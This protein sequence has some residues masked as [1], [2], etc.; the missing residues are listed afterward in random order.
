MPHSEERQSS[1]SP[2]SSPLSSASPSVTADDLDRAVWLAVQL[3]ERAPADAWNNK[4]G[5]LEWDCWETVE[6]L[7]DDLFV[8]ATQLGPRKPPLTSEVPFTWESRRPGGPGSTLFADRAAGPSGLL[9]VLE[10]SCALLVAM[11]RTTSPDAR[12]YHAYGVSDPEG[13]AAMGIVET[14]VHTHDLAEGLGLAWTPPAELCA[15]VLV[16]L[17]PQA[18][19]DTDP[20]LTLLWATGRGELPGRPRLSTWRWDGTPRTSLSPPHAEA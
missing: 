20:W 5:A 1:L 15:R 12:A 3:L 14:L 9:Q 7:S 13:F 8:Y 17:F 11:V 19:T 10:A 4:A 16:R 6:H 2:S 18:P